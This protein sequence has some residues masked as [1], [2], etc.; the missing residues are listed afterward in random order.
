MAKQEKPRP[1]VAYVR[2][3]Y[4]NPTFK[5]ASGYKVF[6]AWNEEH[7]KYAVQNYGAQCG[8]L[9]ADSITKEE[10]ESNTQI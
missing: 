6:W 8:L 3:T 10:Y 5:V 9:S 4:F 7:L 1:H 2:F